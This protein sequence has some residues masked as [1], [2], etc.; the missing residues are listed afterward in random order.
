M[1]QR[2]KKCTDRQTN[3]QIHSGKPEQWFFLLTDLVSVSLF[4]ILTECKCHGPP[5]LL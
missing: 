5:E 2:A 4:L 1:P 3:F